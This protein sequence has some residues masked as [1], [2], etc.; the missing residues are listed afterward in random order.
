MDVE[1]SHVPPEFSLVPRLWVYQGALAGPR[2]V[3]P[4]QLLG[5]LVQ[6]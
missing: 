6:Q 4:W 5:K 2:P 1:C 3:P